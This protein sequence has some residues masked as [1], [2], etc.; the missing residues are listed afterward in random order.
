[1]GIEF[2]VA[3]ADEKTREMRDR[4]AKVVWEGDR[5]NCLCMNDVA[6]AEEKK[7]FEHD[8]GL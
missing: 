8:E 6:Y 7:K 1:M 5:I 3:N 2:V 4:C